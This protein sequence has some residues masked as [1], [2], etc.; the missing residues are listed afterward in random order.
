[1]RRV[2]RL[3]CAALV[4]CAVAVVTAVA[5]AATPRA[6]PAASAI[7][8]RGP[9]TAE[10]DPRGLLPLTAH[11]IGPATTAALRFLGRN[12]VPQAYSAG[13]ATAGR[14]HGLTAR[15]ACGAQVL[16]RTIVV[17]IRLCSAVPDKIYYVGRLQTGYRVWRV[18][19]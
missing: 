9:T 4:V 7:C 12:V 3:G 5:P 16:S 1:V 6:A 13:L 17:R 18:V 19:R 15:F 10:V 8:S 14:E 2:V 11:S